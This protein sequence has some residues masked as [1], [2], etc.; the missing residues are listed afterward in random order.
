MTFLL[1]F[2]YLVL[3]CWLLTKIKFITKSNLENRTLIILF[4][5]RILA[6]MANAWIN[7]YYYSETDSTLFQQESIIEY[8]LLLSNPKEYLFNI[9]QNNTGTSYTGIFDIT[10]SFWNNLRTNIIIKLLSVFNILSN[11]NYFINTLF[12][13]FL[14]FFGSIS[15]YRIFIQIFPLKKTTLLI[16]VF[17]L[18]SCLYFTSGLHRDG[19]VFLALG[20]VCFNMYNILK[21]RGVKITR[22]V[23]IF[24]GLLLIFLLRNFIFITLLPALTAWIVAEKRQKFIFPTFAIIYIFFILLFFS[25]KYI[26][27]KLDL[28]QY[29]SSRQLAFIQIASKAASTI[30]I[31][32]LFPDFRSFFNNAPQA[33]NHTLMRPYLSENTTRLYFPLALEIFFYESLLLAYFFFPVKRAVRDSFI[34]FGLFFVFSMF[35]LIGY[36]IPI[37]GAIVRYRS[38]YFPFLITPLACLINVNKIKLALDYKK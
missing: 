9:F 10:D 27:P 2:I 31:N 3:L 32:P 24:F 14:V 8:H 38:I 11:S 5:L 19:L 13:N 20:I 12:Y 35:L 34:Y 28:P 6:G 21:K 36:T 22:F 37:L 16:T 15:L 1:F 30:N 7:L 17:L 26:H 29:V 4:L 25:L 23:Y 18:P 33:L